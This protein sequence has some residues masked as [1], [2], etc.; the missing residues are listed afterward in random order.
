MP[1][2]FEAKTAESPEG[3][4]LK[5]FLASDKLDAKLVKYVV[6]LD[7]TPKGLA[8][9]AQQG[10]EQA[11]LIG[12]LLADDELMKQ[13]LVADGASSTGRGTPAQ[14]GSAMA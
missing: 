6:L 13:M 2:T 7:A 11:A 10:K 9:F 12:Q 5:K 14:Y 1:G 8:E 3:Q 4:Q